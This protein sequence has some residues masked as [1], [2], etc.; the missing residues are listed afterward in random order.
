MLA[1]P[2]AVS[3]A[4]DAIAGEDKVKAGGRAFR[5]EITELGNHRHPSIQ[6][7]LDFHTLIY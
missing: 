1:L 3:E 5:V 7:V 4:L 6:I 2:A